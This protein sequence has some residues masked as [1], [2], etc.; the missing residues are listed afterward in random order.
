MEAPVSK[1]RFDNTGTYFIVSL[2]IDGYE[3]F[4]ASPLGLP[5]G[6]HYE[7][8]LTPGSHSYEALF[9]FWNEYG[10]REYLYRTTGTFV[11]RSGVIEVVPL[12]GPTISD[13]L[14]K[15]SN[16]G[17]WSAWIPG[18]F[19]KASYRFYANGTYQFYVGSQLTATGTYTFVSRNATA[20]AVTFSDGYNQGVLYEFLGY[21]VMY[22]G[23]NGAALQY[24]YEGS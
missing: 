23:P 3:Q 2:K 17:L 20:W 22:N 8:D 4:P 12:P 5:G 16:S 9:G 6:Y 1:T 7:I 10:Q 15:F 13:L 24:F 11:Q 21:F 19:E 14:T 18:S